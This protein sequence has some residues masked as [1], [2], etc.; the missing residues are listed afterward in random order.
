MSAEPGVAVLS[1]TGRGVALR[2]LPSPPAHPEG[3]I[4]AHRIERL[5]I[6]TAQERAR[7]V[8]LL[9]QCRS[10]A[11]RARDGRVMSMPER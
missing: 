2:A 9:D 6:A 10:T 7:T 3:A 11:A 4:L 8:V 5:R 1:D